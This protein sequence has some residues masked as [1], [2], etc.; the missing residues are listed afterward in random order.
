MHGHPTAWHLLLVSSSFIQSNSCAVP[1]IF[2]HSLRA[3]TICPLSNLLRS[4][5]FPNLFESKGKAGTLP[6]PA[7]VNVI[8]A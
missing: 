6:S 2:I 1:E 7:A 4:T 3:I 5:A 8:P